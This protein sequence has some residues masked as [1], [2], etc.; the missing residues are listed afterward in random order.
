M[1]FGLCNAPATFQRLMDLV[2]SG[3]NWAHCLIYLDDVIVLGRSFLEHRQNL[4]MVFACLSEAGLKL[5]LA[6]CALFRAEVQF[7]GH[8]VSRE[9]IQ[10]DPSNVERVSK[11][12]TPTTTRDVQQFLG[13]ASYYRRFVQDFATIAKPLHHLTE[14]GAPFLWT[15]ECQSAFEKLRHLLTTTPMLAYPD[16]N[17]PFILDTDTSGVGI[18]A[19]LSQVDGEG[20]ERLIACGSRVLSK[21]ERQY[22]VTRRELLAVV[23]FVKQFQPYLLGRNSL[24]GWTM[25]P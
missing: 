6:K 23:S 14:D 13:F 12:P 2:L 22:C 7:L 5:K 8:L 19:I 24:C 16:F 4:Q 25:V 17:W 1:P 3:L 10:A 18:G 20:R 15:E 21:A 11:W 9:G